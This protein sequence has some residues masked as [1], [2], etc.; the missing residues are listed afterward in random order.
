M[1]LKREGSGKL[2]LKE[3]SFKKKTP[4]QVKPGQIK[5]GY[6]ETYPGKLVSFFLASR[7]A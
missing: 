7:K 5:P 1:V 6:F 3:L 2:N 4:R